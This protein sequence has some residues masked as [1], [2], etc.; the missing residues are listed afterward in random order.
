MKKT[1]SIFMAIALFICGNAQ[2]KMIKEVF[3]LL[4]ADKI[5]GLTVGTRDSMLRGKTY[6]PA[7]NDSTSTEAYNYGISTNVKNY[8]YVSMSYETAQR[9]SSMVEIRRF[10][11]TKGENLIVVSQTGGVWPI[12]YQQN[13]LS[14]FIYDGGKKLIPYKKRLLPSADEMIFMKSGIPDSIKQKILDNS[15]ITFNFS[16]EKPTLELNND[17]LTDDILIKKWLKGDFVEFTW[18]GDRFTATKIGFRM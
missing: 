17:Y 14:L 8:M 7:D 13:D 10:K 5:Y 9:A 15:N 18:S 16:S 6:Y 3:R 11:T 1:A 4:P 2:T 12:N